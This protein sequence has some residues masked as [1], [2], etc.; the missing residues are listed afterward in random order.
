MTYPFSNTSALNEVLNSKYWYS[1]PFQEKNG[2]EYKELDNG[3]FQIAMNVLGINPEDIEITVAGTDYPNRQILN[4]VG[5]SEILDH[6]F[7]VNFRFIV[8]KMKTVTPTFKNGLLIVEIEWE[9]PVN[10]DVEIKKIA[11]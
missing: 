10:P 1:R 4:I 5:E 2:Y 8:K 7:Q 11:L 3:N 9:K 6:K